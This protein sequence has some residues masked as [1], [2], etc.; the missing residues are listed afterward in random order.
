MLKISFSVS[1]E[2]TF[3]LNKIYICRERRGKYYEEEAY[4]LYQKPE[5]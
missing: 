1:Q 5:S 3:K 2:R 4:D